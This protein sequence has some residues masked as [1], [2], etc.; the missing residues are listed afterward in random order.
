MEITGSKKRTEK[1]PK[2]ALLLYH[3]EILFSRLEEMARELGE[4]GEERV[5][6]IPYYQMDGAGPYQCKKLLT[7]IDEEFN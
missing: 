1:E 4:E 2:M 7:M 3:R 5:E 6:I